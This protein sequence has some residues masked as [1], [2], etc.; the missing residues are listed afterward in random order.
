MTGRSVDDHPLSKQGN[1]W[2]PVDTDRDFGS[3][4][5]FDDKAR[6]RS[7]QQVLARFTG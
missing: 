6:P 1:L 4:G 5:D 2:E 7:L 3:H